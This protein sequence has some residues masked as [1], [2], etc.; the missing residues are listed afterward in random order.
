MAISGFPFKHIVMQPTTLCNLDCD[1]CYL[2]DKTEPNKMPYG[3]AEA[4]AE[5]IKNAPHSMNVLWHGGEPLACG[6]E[7]FKT[8]LEP[9]EPLRLAGKI[10]H[11]IQIN[12]TL[13]SPDWCRLFRERNFSVGISIDGPEGCNI[14]RVN[15]ANTPA[16]DRIMKGI[17]LLKLNRIPFGV[18]AVVSESNIGSAKSFYEFFLALGCKNLCVNI[19]E[20]EGVNKEKNHLS[21]LSVKRF[22]RELFEEWKDNPALRIREF[23]KSLGWLNPD[24][25]R[26]GHKKESAVAVRDMWPTVA[27]NGNVV[28]LSPEFLS[29]EPE[30]RKEFFVGN[31]LEKPL[32]EIVSDSFNAE[33]VKDYFLGVVK[34]SGTCNY[35]SFCGG[36]R[37]SNKYFELGKINTT[38]TEEC[39]NT[40]MLLVDSISEVIE[41][42]T[43]EGAGIRVE[44]DEQGGSGG[45]IESDESVM[46][47]ESLESAD[48]KSRQEKEDF[49]AEY[50]CSRYA[51]F[52]VNDPAALLSDELELSGAELLWSDWSDRES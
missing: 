48:L 9:F 30:I 41:C 1:Y 23:D 37:A 22:W 50:V 33:Y 51:G 15:R 25:S 8:L 34:C 39:R 12:G 14:N 6:L 32:Y 21:A 43:P 46:C 3:V 29:V 45:P 49:F 19:V 36:G 5:S 28:M 52:V 31:I 20:S 47:I 13:I 11:S 18:I 10:E 42:P 16:W 4:V 7:H 17:G 26:A 35:F 2:P 40:K 38:E 27:W 44:A 24:R